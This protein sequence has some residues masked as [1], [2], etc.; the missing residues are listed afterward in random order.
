[1]CI[2]NVY[3][4]YQVNVIIAMI[5]LTTCQQKGKMEGKWVLYT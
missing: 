4:L 5:F 3:Y 2:E 1:M